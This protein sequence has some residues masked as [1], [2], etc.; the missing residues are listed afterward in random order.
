MKEVTIL[1]STGSVGRQALDVVRRFPERLRVFGLAAGSNAELLAE[2]TREFGPGVVALR[3]TDR[4]G[5]LGRMLAGTD[6]EILTGENGICDLAARRGPA[7]VLSAISGFA[8][9][10]P[11]LAACRGG[12]DLA[13]ANKEAVVCAGSL[14]MNEIQQAG[15]TLIPVDSEHNAL[16]QCLIGEN[17]ADVDRLILTAS[18]GPFWNTPA[19]Q[20]ERVTPEQA[21]AHPRWDMGRKI[22]V[23][24]ATL[25]NKGL[26]IVEAHWLFRVPLSRIDVVVHPQSAVHSVVRFS[27]GSLKMHAG[28]AD[29]RYPVQHAFSYPERWDDPGY[30]DFELAGS[31]LVF[32]EPDLDRF[33]C[34]TLARQ[35]GEAGGVYPT[36]LVSTDEVAVS[37]F[38]AGKIPFTG[39]PRLIDGVL[40][41]VALSTEHPVSIDDILSIDDWAR[42]RAEDIIARGL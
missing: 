35:A 33:P 32:E 30:A 28:A 3:D 36:V 10:E 21:L 23:D 31:R 34:L 29:M 7:V 11:T 38:L 41:E 8:G 26:E 18:G 16:F 1:G 14:L 2:Q 22:S 19:E 4:A 37:A 39:I 6:A 25:M 9:L 15:I 12:A 20:L 27:D 40:G 13:L 42:R 5:D 17:M 24:S